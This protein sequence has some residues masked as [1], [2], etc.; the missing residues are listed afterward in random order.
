[1]S[2]IRVGPDGKPFVCT[3]CLGHDE[4]VTFAEDLEAGVDILIAPP[5]CD[6]CARAHERWA[7]L[8]FVHVIGSGH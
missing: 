3:C 8:N 2:V 5:V 4:D 7:L 6:N 1:M